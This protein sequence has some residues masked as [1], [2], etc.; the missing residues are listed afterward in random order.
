MA[1]AYE[2]SLLQS[3]IDAESGYATRYPVRRARS[4]RWPVIAS[5]AA[6]SLLAY[7]V[8][9]G[10]IRGGAPSGAPASS[11]PATGDWC[12]QVEPLLP[13]KNTA[14]LS[15]LEAYLDTVEFRNQSASRLSGAIQ[16]P[17]ESY[18]DLGAVGEDPRWDTMYD[19][20]AYLEKTFP[21]VY[22]TLKLE[23]LNSHGLL[24]TWEGTDESLKPTVLMA[25]QDVVPVAKATIDRWTYPPYSGAYDG[26]Y[27][28]GRGA[29]DCKNTLVGILE[30]VELLVQ[31]DFAPKRTVILSF[32]FDEEVSGF[33]GAG[34]LAGALLERYG[35]GGV[36]MLVDEGD[37]VYEAWGASFGAP[38]VSEKGYVD[39]EIIVRAPGGHSS[40]P[41]THTGIGIMSELIALVESHPYTSHFGEGNP[42][43]G[44]LQ[45]GAAHAPDFPPEWKALLPAPGTHDPRLE[46]ELAREVA[47][48]PE[49]KFLIT[50]SSAVD[51]IEGGVKANALPERTTALVNHRVNIGER[52]RD[53]EKHMTPLAQQ[54]ADKYNLTLHAFDGPETPSSITLVS[55]GP[56]EPAPV[57][58]TGIDGATPYAILS[59]TTRALYGEHVL[60]TPGIG[61]GNTDTI[62]YWDLTRHIFRYSPGWDPKGDGANAHTVDETISM[63]NHVNVVKWYI[64]FI[65]N[66]DEAQLLD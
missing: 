60:M 48:Q 10:G 21:A 37:G 62:H 54:V 64:M 40:V 2:K 9:S 28:W 18:D 3:H 63:T 50:T 47:K 16:F 13:A 17:T 15:R 12:P 52:V 35:P 22:S 49:L 11:A 66:V 30:A 55:R 5:L 32:G 46:E 20:A 24:F 61:S 27:V 39:V 29:M 6:T 7:S 1:A 44:L 34:H 25:H 4:S 45:C 14:P 23:K 56:L 26:R 65:R 36:G 43:L 8:F 59:G 57:A 19:L 41:P 58:P 53:V 33:E 38:D 51:I 31:A 42:L